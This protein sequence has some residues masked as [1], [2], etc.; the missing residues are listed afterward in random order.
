M[1]LAQYGQWD[2]S[3]A[4]TCI[5]KWL[6]VPRNL[7]A[8]KE[9]LSKNILYSPTKEQMKILQQKIDAEEKRLKET[10]QPPLLFTMSA[11]DRIVPSLS[12]NTSHKIL[13]TI[14]KAEE[15]VP[16]QLDADFVFD[17][18][19][20]EWAYVLD[21]D[22]NVLEVYAGSVETS[23]PGRSTRFDF[24]CSEDDDKPPKL[25]P[26]LIQS[27]NLSAL[28]E[29]DDD[30]LL[31]Y[32]DVEGS[33]DEDDD[34]DDDED[35]DE[36]DEEASDETDDETRNEDAQG[37]S[38]DT[39]QEPSNGM[40]QVTSKDQGDEQSKEAAQQPPQ[41]NAQDPTNDKTQ[42][43]SN[44]KVEDPSHA[45]IPQP[46]NEKTAEPLNHIAEK[47]SNVKIHPESSMR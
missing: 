3:T 19:F 29:S 15:P 8:L 18:L 45:D 10:V 26:R 14:I 11:I 43:P 46:S 36:D 5:L 12:R 21:L 38:K 33:Y 22:E 6:R 16:V 47:I 27:Y 9:K 17:Y 4:G 1:V 13:N 41:G 20:C 30:Y 35:D 7:T 37:S 40:A 23:T 34:V 39:A 31:S 44:D 24:L 32:K 42:Q 2:G 28:P 25:S